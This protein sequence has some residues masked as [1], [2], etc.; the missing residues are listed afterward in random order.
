MTKKTILWL[1]LTVALSVG[2]HLLTMW[3]LPYFMTRRLAGKMLLNELRY[4]NLRY[5]GEDKIPQDNPDTK[6]SATRYDVSDKP[7]RLTCVI[8]QTD[9][10]WSVSFF[11][12]N[13][14]NFFVLNDRKAARPALTLV[15][16]GPGRHYTARAN[17]QVVQ[18]P[19]ATG[20]ILIRMI[21]KD[22]YNKAEIDAITAIQKQ[23]N[24][25]LVADAVDY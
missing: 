24:A 12:Q 25:Q 7:L 11:A 15:L 22:R 21:V 23:S 20:V 8:P 16:V 1:L 17:E 9:N 5:A 6:V 19:S 14:D 13:T 4:A 3:R 2:L 10:Y 18:S